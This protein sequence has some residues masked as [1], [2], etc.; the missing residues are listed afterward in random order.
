MVSPA[1]SPSCRVWHRGMVTGRRAGAISSRAAKAAVS[2]E[3]FYMKAKT[4][5]YTMA[6]I[7]RISFCALLGITRE[8]QQTPPSYL[9][10]LGANRRGFRTAH[11][12][13]ISAIY[14]IRRKAAATAGICM[15]DRLRPELQLPWRGSGESPGFVLSGE[16]SSIY[17]KNGRTRKVHTGGVGVRV[18]DK[19][20]PVQSGE[21][22]VHGRIGGK[23]GFQGVNIGRKIAK[24]GSGCW[25]PGISPIPPGGR[26]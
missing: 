13:G 3:D 25:A 18:G 12:P 24:R 17:K 15:R 1:S 10:V 16:I 6:R 23:A 9:R 14:R 22:P 19:G 8:L 7:R 11:L 2:L 20:V 21:P 5:R 4:K 26:S